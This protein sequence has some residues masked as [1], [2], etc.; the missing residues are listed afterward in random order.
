MVYR[1]FPPIC[2]SRSPK[3]SL[4][5]TCA[6][7][8]A[9]F[10]FRRLHRVMRSQRLLLSDLAYPDASVPVFMTVGVPAPRN[11]LVRITLREDDYRRRMIEIT[12]ACSLPSASSSDPAGVA[13][14]EY[15]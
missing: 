13:S 15:A 11:Q 2:R 14:F 10:S 5:K 6:R 9:G 1:R 8:T 3:A 12:P 4:P 7:A